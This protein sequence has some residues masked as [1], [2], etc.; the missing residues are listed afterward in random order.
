MS[1]MDARAT[2]L[3]FHALHGLDDGPATLEES[4]ELLRLAM[5]D[6]TDTVVATPHVR[7]DFVTD[8]SDLP[9]RVRELSAA[10][11]AEGIAIDLRVGG[12]LG[13]DMVGRLSQVELS[14]IAQGPAGARWLLVEAPWQPMDDD[15]HAATDELRDRG[16]GVMIAHPERSADAALDDSAGLRRELAAG[17][18]AQVNAQSIT[19]HHGPDARAAANK[20]IDRGWSASW[21]PT[22]TARRGRRFWER[23]AGALVTIGSRSGGPAGS[24]L[25]VSQL[26]LSYGKFRSR[27]DRD[28]LPQWRYRG[29]RLENRNE[30]TVTR[31]PS[32]R[33]VVIR[34]AGATMELSRDVERA[35]GAMQRDESARVRDLEAHSRDRAAEARDRH[36]EALAL[37]AQSGSPGE[38][39]RRLERALS[40]LRAQ[41]MADRQQ[42]RADR[43]AARRDREQAAVDRRQRRIDGRGNVHE[44]LLPAVPDSVG[45]ARRQVAERV[46]PGLTGRALDDL[47]LAVSEAVANAVQHGASDEAIRL[48]VESAGKQVRV[49]V[50]D[51]SPRFVHAPG[52]P[53]AE[54]NGGWGLYLIETLASRWGIE[55]EDRQTHVWFEIQPEAQAS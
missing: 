48:S 19:G 37:R 11:S 34:E 51:S 54:H 23:C 15:F 14:L 52:H 49:S 2:E 22:P 5:L 1:Q 16:F 17:S 20:L 47:L 39:M 33:S 7:G 44:A 43:Q 6:G 45:E 21:P 25:G 18:L 29:L 10:A 46:S 27:A 42:A 38:R 8:V 3:H 26:A 4:V 12:E 24:S 35:R 9:A 13:H 40:G 36:A 30:F 32:T 55:R 41:A 53:S 28:H 50:T 31:W